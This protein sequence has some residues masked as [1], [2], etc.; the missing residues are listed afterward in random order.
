MK[1]MC[2]VVDDH[3]ITAEA[4]MDLLTRDLHDFKCSYLNA[5]TAE[6]A[7]AQIDKAYELHKSIDFALIDINIPPYKYRNINSGVDVACYLKSKFPN[8]ILIILT[9]HDE[10]L[11]INRTFKVL[12]PEGFI[13][14]ADIDFESF[15]K[16]VHEILHGKTYYSEKIAQSLN[17]SFN[18]DENDYQIILML[19]RNIKTK[20]MPNFIDLSLSSIEKRKANIK[21]YLVSQ[22]I[23]DKE[24]LD[25]CKKIKLI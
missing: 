7:C 15:P 2:L 11:I 6:Q 3:P 14:K 20:D 17:I 1:K 5:G 22:K 13:S 16:I 10:Y 24:L 23:S 21:R 8:C 19:E 4:Y 9:M 12:N 25:F 18:W